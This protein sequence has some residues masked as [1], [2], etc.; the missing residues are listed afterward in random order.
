MTAPAGVVEIVR[1][2]KALVFDFDGTLVDSN[3][4]KWRAFEI[5]FAEFREQLDGITAYCRQ[6]NHTGRSEKFRYVYE[7]ILGLD[8]NAGIER[9][10]EDRFAAATTCQI[11]EAP[12]IPGASRLLAG[13][14]SCHI[15]ALLS[16]TPHEPLLQ[17]VSERGWRSYFT[18]IQGAPVNKAAWL[19]AFRERHGLGEHDMV[20]FGDTPEDAAAARAAGCTFVAV[21]RDRHML[22]VIFSVAD[23]TELVRA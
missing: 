11:I 4:I 12:E 6:N 10:L 23:L 18:E 9:A 7:H 20:F 3:E 14:A 19:R 8:Y 22:Q 16:S 17:I 1:R 2:A 13:A 21:G 15:M 5:C